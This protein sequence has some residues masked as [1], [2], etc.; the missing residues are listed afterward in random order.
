MTINIVMTTYCPEEGH[1]R[2]TYGPRAAESLY[3]RLVCYNEPR[4]KLR[5]IVANDGPAEQPHCQAIAN[6]VPRWDDVLIVGGDRVGIG[7]SLNR[8]LK[9]V[10]DDDQ[11]FY[12]TDDWMLPGD[13]YGDIIDLQ[14]PLKLIHAGYDYVRVGPPHPNTHA[15][16]RFR[17]E[18]GWWL[19]LLPEY[20]HFVFATRPFLATKN[21][22]NNVGPFIEQKNSYDVEIEYNRAVLDKYTN[23]PEKLAET[24]HGSLEGYWEH[25]GE[26]NVG[27]VYP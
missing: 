18:L 19:E 22:Y 23:V 5:F 20:G 16:I 1:V 6:A 2:G 12:T 24:V 21:F 15:I 26:F 8:A 27:E 11:W 25:I 13:E 10:G 17:Q 7:G 4:E 3:T 14:R 9:H